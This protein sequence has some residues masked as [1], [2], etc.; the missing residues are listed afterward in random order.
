MAKPYDD[1]VEVTPGSAVCVSPGGALTRCTYWRVLVPSSGGDVS[2]RRS[3]NLKAGRPATFDAT[4][5]QGLWVDAS[6]NVYAC[7]GGTVW[8]FNEQGVEQATYSLPAGNTAKCLEVDSSGNV[9]VGC[10]RGGTTKVNLVKL[11][12]SLVE[13]WKKEVETDTVHGIA[14]ESDTEIH[15]VGGANADDE[16]AWE[17]DEDGNETAN[18]SIGNGG[19][20]TLYDIVFDNGGNEFIAA[21]ADSDVTVIWKNGS[22]WQTQTLAFAFCADLSIGPDDEVVGA[23]NETG[24]GGGGKVI[25]YTSAGA[26][27]WSHTFTGLVTDAAVV[28]DKDG[29]VYAVS[30][31]TVRKLDVDDGSQLATASP[32]A[33]GDIVLHRDLRDFVP[34]GV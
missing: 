20:V 3:S 11:N 4:A 18:R 30:N 10:D 26:E 16:N 6:N 15:I 28:V 9:Y 1:R 14:I 12:S 32:V 8:K 27:D 24:G 29:H 2:T 17:F 34:A 25:R 33:D 7:G 19:P 5:V 23:I 13:Q 21:Q 31:T 22:S